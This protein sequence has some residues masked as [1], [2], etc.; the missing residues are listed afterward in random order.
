MDIL[1]EFWRSQPSLCNKVCKDEKYERL[2]EKLCDYQ[3]SVYDI[4]PDDKIKVIEQYDQAV[5]EL[6]NYT[7]LNAFKSGFLFCIKTVF[8]INDD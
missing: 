5:I 2:M 6:T 7:E 3:K 4:L 8:G 1:E